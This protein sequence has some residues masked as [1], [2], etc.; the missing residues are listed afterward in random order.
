MNIHNTVHYIPHLS[1]H[2]QQHYLHAISK[3]NATNQKNILLN[4]KKISTKSN[5]LNKLETLL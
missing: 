1:T 2:L 3:H 4:T 5:N